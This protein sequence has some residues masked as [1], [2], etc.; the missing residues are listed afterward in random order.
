MIGCG[1][2]EGMEPALQG[3]L[4]YL[5]DSAQNAQLFTTVAIPDSLGE[6]M[7]G[8][9]TGAVMAVGQRPGRPTA[10]LCFLASSVCTTLLTSLSKIADGFSS[11]LSCLFCVHLGRSKTMRTLSD[12]T[13]GLSAYS[14]PGISRYV[15]HR[16]FSDRTVRHLVPTLA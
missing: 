10:G 9:L 8:P 11:Y 2:G 3:F 4:T 14:F 5:S 15:S 7:G 13:P 16:S 12:K 1:L 6:L